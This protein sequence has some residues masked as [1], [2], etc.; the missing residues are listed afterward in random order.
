[1]TTITYQFDVGQTVWHV[2]LND[3][4]REGVV[5]TLEIKQV[6]PAIAPTIRYTSQFINAANGSVTDDEANFYAD[7]DSALNA[8]KILL[9]N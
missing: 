8:Y 1:M 4:V 7:I 3:G 5:K 9:L 6:F 2:S